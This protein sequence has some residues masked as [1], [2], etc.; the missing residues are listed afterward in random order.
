MDRWNYEMGIVHY[1]RMQTLGSYEL[2][3]TNGK[4]FVAPRVT[5]TVGNLQTFIIAKHHPK[6][7]RWHMQK[8]I[9]MSNVKQ[10][11]VKSQIYKCQRHLSPSLQEDGSHDCNQ[12]WNQILLFS[13]FF[14]EKSSV[15]HPDKKVTHKP[16]GRHPR[17]SDRNS[18]SIDGGLNCWAGACPSKINMK[19]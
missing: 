11:M 16:E 14:F 7:W 12:T 17:T 5:D 9:R 2:T 1:W 3:C 15:F 10:I 18:A 13:T 4:L 19:M 8:I 6:F